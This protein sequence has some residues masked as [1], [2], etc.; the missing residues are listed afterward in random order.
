[1]NPVDAPAC[2][3]HGELMLW[4]PSTRL[5]A[6]GRWQCRVV[7]RER[8]RR[9]REANAEKQ[10]A[11]EKRWRDNNKE[12]TAER[13]RRWQK[14][15]PEKVREKARRHYARHREAMVEK[16]R[17]QRAE[18]PED[19]R[20]RNR[21]YRVSHRLECR[22]RQNLRR[23]QKL[24]TDCDGYA[25][26]ERI[27]ARI[28]FYGHRC[29]YCGG[30]HEALDHRIPLSR[31]GPHLPANLVPSCQWCNSSKGSKTETEFRG[32]QH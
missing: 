30:P 23:A 2:E 9:W 10:K 11:S 21:R 13:V 28:A 27:A 19:Q 32:R 5:R 18:N 15:N 12:R 4:Q 20:E 31:G 24:G 1:M 14:D 29:Y 3:C 26:I 22:A 16:D 6:G 7:H 8:N 25:T 17:R